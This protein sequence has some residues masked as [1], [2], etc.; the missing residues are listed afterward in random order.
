[1][2]TVL[3]VD[4][5]P[6]MRYATVRVL[7]AAG[8]DVRETA[9]A[10]DALRLARLGLDLIILDIALND[11]DGF[12]VVRRLRADPATQAIPVVHKTAVFLEENDRRRGLAAGADE[13]LVEPVPPLVLV[14]TVRRLLK[15]R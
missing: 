8:F 4:D 10:R 1:M 12:E 9:T 7:E 11:L 2:N 14:E 6:D 5:R 13:Y 3:V 15:S